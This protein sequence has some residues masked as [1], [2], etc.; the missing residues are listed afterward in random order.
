MRAFFET[1]PLQSTTCFG[2]TFSHSR[3]YPPEIVG[4]SADGSLCRLKSTVRL[5]QRLSRV[6]GDLGHGSL[7]CAQ[8]SQRLVH[9][10]PFNVCYPG[11]ARTS[12]TDVPMRQP[13]TLGYRTNTLAR[14][15]I[16]FI[17]SMLVS[18]STHDRTALDT[19]GSALSFSSCSKVH[20]FGVRAANQH[21]SR[22][23]YKPGSRSTRSIHTAT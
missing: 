13:S 1:H 9:L 4:G 7:G 10:E 16:A 11:S 12:G 20:T 5:T 8:F 18:T 14:T 21:E 3:M 23:F 22:T 6:A 19:L 17:H 2:V 15:V